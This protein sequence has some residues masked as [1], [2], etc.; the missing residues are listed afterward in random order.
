MLHCRLSCRSVTFEAFFGVFAVLFMALLQLWQ[1]V[2]VKRRNECSSGS[3]L[4][5]ETPVGNQ[6]GSSSELLRRN[7]M[8]IS[9]IGCENLDWN[10]EI[11]IKPERECVRKTDWKWQKSVFT[12]CVTRGGRG[13]GRR[14]EAGGAYSRS[15][16]LLPSARCGGRRVNLNAAFTAQCESR[17]RPAG[18][19]SPSPPLGFRSTYWWRSQLDGFWRFWRF[20]GTQ[21]GAKRG[22]LDAMSR[23]KLGSRP[24]HLS[25]IQGKPEA[26]SDV[27]ARWACCG[28]EVMLLFSVIESKTNSGHTL[29][30]IVS[31]RA[32][33]WM[34]AGTEY[35]MMDGRHYFNFQACKTI[36]KRI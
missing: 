34:R 22:T 17:Q 2:S 20:L 26:S 32:R 1:L 19:I 28:R 3:G 25:A 21:K 6:R 36:Y 31:L 14:S 16:P 18:L 13:Q 10:S 12:E 8:F 11:S 4:D 27:C 30:L 15:C 29:C 9:S 24:Q 7:F 35:Q 5:L 33:V 23:R